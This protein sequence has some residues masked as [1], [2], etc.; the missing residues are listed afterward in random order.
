MKDLA[1][2]VEKHYSA[3][4][5]FEAIMENLKRKGIDLARVRARD[6]YPY[7]QSHAGGI[8]ATA[9]L[10]QRAGIQ[11]DMVVV[12][13]GCGIGGAA[14][15]LRTEFACRVLG[16]DLTP[17][18]LRAALELNRMV[19]LAEGI[20][21]LAALADAMPFPSEFAD[22]MWTQHVTMNLPQHRS[23]VRECWRVLKPSGR[24]AFHEWFLTRPGPP[25]SPLSYPLPWAP[26]PALNHAVSSEEFLGILRDEHF[27][28][29]AEDVTVAMIARLRKDVQALTARGAPA[30]RLAA[31]EN[32]VKAASDG[33]LHCLMIR[34]ARGAK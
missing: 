29:A 17:A 2:S 31:H 15:Y 34:G 9:M 30:Q 23:F 25:S 21:L 6:L 19:G 26:N 18:R 28:P 11:R 16:I 22:V 10:A 33:L 20:D 24:L 27:I 4:T 12:D 14:R 1:A 32:L 5:G 13:I 8:E 7:D 3:W